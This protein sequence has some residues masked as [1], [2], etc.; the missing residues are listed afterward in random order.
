M[1]GVAFIAVIGRRRRNERGDAAR[2]VEGPPAEPPRDDRPPLAQLAR[3]AAPYLVLVTLVLATRLVPPV[4]DALLG[5]DLGWE[6]AGGTFSGSLT[7]LYHPGSMLLFALL[8]G[9]RVQGASAGHVRVALAVTPRDLVPV[10]V[11]LVAMLSLARVLVHAGMIESIASAA[12]D[13]V[14]GR[15]WLPPWGCSARS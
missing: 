5:V 2:S 12:A 15:C 7:P 6:A 8:V 1:G 3:A 4:R 9:A 10:A 13:A 11:A 14:A